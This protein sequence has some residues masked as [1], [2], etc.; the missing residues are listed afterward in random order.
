MKNGSRFIALRSDGYP[1]LIN[2]FFKITKLS[3]AFL[4]CE[5]NFIQLRNQSTSW[6]HHNSMRIDLAIRAGN[7]V[8]CILLS[9]TQNNLMDQFEYDL[10]IICLISYP[11]AIEMTIPGHTVYWAHT[12]SFLFPFFLF[13]FLLP[14]TF[15][16]RS[17]SFSR[18]SLMSV[19]FKLG[20]IMVVSLS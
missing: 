11:T 13:P 9:W 1:F 19:G 20:I 4:E 7:H 15:C 12:I 5:L 18:A 8:I 16:W 10:S 2:R 6:R 14:T 3:K 17:H